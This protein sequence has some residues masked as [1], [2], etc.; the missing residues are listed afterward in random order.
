MNCVEEVPY[1]WRKD[2]GW[3]SGTGKKLLDHFR[4]CRCPKGKLWIADE[5]ELKEN[6]E[7]K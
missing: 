5:K 3:K 1:R 7:V 4:M 6:G 2:Y